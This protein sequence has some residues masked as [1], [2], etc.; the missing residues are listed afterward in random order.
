MPGAPRERSGCA[1]RRSAVA[2][3]LKKLA[4]L[5]LKQADG[6]SAYIAGIVDAPMMSANPFKLQLADG[7]AQPN[8]LGPVL[9]GEAS[10]QVDVSRRR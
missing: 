1:S 6:H 4:C 10:L 5:S 3:R 8:H 2:E 9:L 7:L